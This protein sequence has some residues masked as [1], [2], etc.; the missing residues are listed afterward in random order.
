M[1]LSSDVNA[2]T[3]AK[4]TISAKINTKVSQWS[5]GLK[6][7][8]QHTH[9]GNWYII[10]NISSMN[11]PFQHPLSFTFNFVKRPQEWIRRLEIEHYVFPYRRYMYV[12][13]DHRLKSSRIWTSFNKIRLLLDRTF[14]RG[15]LILYPDPLSTIC[16]TRV[17][18]TCQMHCRGHPELG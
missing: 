2:K 10:I 17:Q 16:I 11:D 4:T 7:G 5:Q 1:Q 14:I 15:D 9:V 12:I 18:K 3:N 13:R 6:S 8:C